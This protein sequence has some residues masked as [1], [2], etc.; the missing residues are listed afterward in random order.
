[1]DKNVTKP[2]W[3]A[4]TGL[5]SLLGGIAYAIASYNLP[6]A[7]FGNPLDPIY[8]PM[9]IAIVLMFIGAVLLIKSKPEAA[10]LAIKN[11]L[12]EDASKKYD[13]RRI[14]YTC[15]ISVVYALTFEHLGY[16]ISTALFMFVMLLITGGRKN[17]LKSALI[18]L[19]FSICVY[20]LFSTMLSVSLPPMPFLEI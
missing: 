9:G 14:L 11:L 6:R 8:F 5:L 3:D 15:I 19:A 12:A 1:M 13:R 10:I 17:L 7:S 4:L 20:L 16:V 2:N 18:A